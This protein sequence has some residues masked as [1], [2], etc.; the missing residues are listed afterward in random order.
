[1]QHVRLELPPPQAPLSAAAEAVAQAAAGL[2]W[3]GS[4]A[5][6]ATQSLLSTA[7]TTGC[8][9]VDG[10]A[11]KLLAQSCPQLR[12]LRLVN[13]S[14]NRLVSACCCPLF[15]RQLAWGT[16]EKAAGTFQCCAGEQMTSAALCKQGWVQQGTG[17]R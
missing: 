16:G 7:S 1:M 14:S 15:F 2:P 10:Y 8:P 13:V 17:L 11:V 5:A 4:V 9:P 6:A 3:D 12:S